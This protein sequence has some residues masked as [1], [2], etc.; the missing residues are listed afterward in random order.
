[1]EGGISLKVCKSCMSVKYCNAECQKK[2]WPTHKKECK[3]RAA[4]LREEALFKDP[5]AK[6]ECPICFLPMPLTLICCMSLPP[7][8]IFSVPIYNFAIANVELAD[9]GME[10]YLLS[11]LREDHL[12]RVRT[13]LLHVW[14]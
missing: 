6:E 3:L 4:E 2:H 12:Q 5:P 9:K 7:A 1:M 10:T 14:E 11:M 13:L 8:T